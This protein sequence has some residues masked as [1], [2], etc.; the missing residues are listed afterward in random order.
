MAGLAWLIPL[1]P[2]ASWLYIGLPSHRA[3]TRYD[4]VGIGAVGIA[5]LLSLGVLWDVIRGGSAAA[6]FTWAVHGSTAITIGYQVDGLTAMMLVV[7]T[8]VS[9]MVQ[10]Y[11]LGYMHGDRRYKR[12][13]A[14]L[15]LFTFAMLGLVLADNLLLLYIFWE[16]VGLSSYLLIG[17]WF[18]DPAN[19]RAA[20]KA[21]LT[22]RAGDVAMFIGI[23][24]LFSQTGTF[25]F[26]ELG[27]LAQ[28][29]AISAQALALGAILLFAGAVGKS[30][31]FPLHVW[32]PD[33]M[34]GPTPVSALIHAATMVAAGVYLVG[35]AYPV[36]A[37]SPEA[38]QVVAWIGGITAIFAATMALVQADI[39]KVLAYSTVSQLGY[40]MLG[41]GLG[42]YTAGLFH[43]ITHAFFKALL[44]LGS[45]S[46]IHATGTQDMH[47]MGG[48]IR[49]MPITGWTWIIGSAALAGIP[50]LAGFWSKD[51]ILLTAY[52]ANPTLFWIGVVA[53][54]MTAFYITRATWLT[55]FGAPRDAE[56]YAQVQESPRVMTVP[57]VILAV[58]AATVG[59]LGAPPLGAPFAQLVH[60]G[61]VHHLEMTSVVTWGVTAAWVLGVLVALA[62]YAGGWISR[63][64]II[65]GLRPV[66][67]LLKNRYYIDDAYDYL[68]VKGSIGLAYV[69]GWLD[70][71]VVDG[72]VNGVAAIT[73]W[74]ADATGLFDREVVDGAVNGV[75]DGVSV[76]SQAFRRLQSGL[77]Q[78]YILA[79]AVTV[80]LGLAIFV[81]GG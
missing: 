49:K 70:R 50:P 65:S 40:M 81:I 2:L 46:V 36:F 37:A 14:V 45:G 72:I 60:F 68:F 34:A 71:V 30:A 29:G 74:F 48:L 58:L 73:R 77:V 47:Q 23:M 11:S 20:N 5:F 54:A 7:V 19:V 42:G 28:A 22:T 53:A 4:R 56:R 12:Y 43:L 3:S 64:R 67:T 69:V 13:Y 25:A 79:M 17:H 76:G 32:L 10:V 55:F 6:S 57:L 75:A 41:L 33:A 44:F 21:F 66:Y 35:R 9:L 39:K 31:Q 38:M 78:S 27:E 52:Y 61:E 62:I 59:F 1:L 16:L 63:Q 15:S 51:E 80:V 24:I 26:G 8:L 18:E